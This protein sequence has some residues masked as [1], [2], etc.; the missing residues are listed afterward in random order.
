M[1]DALLNVLINAAQSGQTTGAVRVTASIDG[2]NLCIAVEDRGAG[3]PAR[4]LPH[5]FDAFYTTRA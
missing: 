3:I 1:R 2:G 4:Q 5:L